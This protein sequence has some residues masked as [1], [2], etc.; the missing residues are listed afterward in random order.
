VE[1]TTRPAVSRDHDDRAS[2]RAADKR[3]DHRLFLRYRDHGDTA[4]REQL[5]ERFLPLA[6][7]LAG[8]YKRRSEPIDDLMQ[9][10]SMGLVKAVDRYDPSRGIAF[11]TFAVPTILGELKRYFRDS[12]WAVRVPRGMQERVLALDQA[13]EELRHRFGHSPSISELASRLDLTSEGVL[14][15]IEA[16]SA[17]ESTSLDSPDDSGESMYAS[18]LGRQESGFE[19]VE[20]RS[21]IV[22][23]ISR[24]SNRQRLVL[25]LRFVEDL[26]QSEIA[27][28]IGV[29]QM[30]VSRLLRRSLEELRAQTGLNDA[31]APDP[32]PRPLRVLRSLPAQ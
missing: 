1:L 2:A 19:L 11:S 6:R 9:V 28:R 21:A 27:D 23:G 32:S 8:R 18:A 14:L 24:L 12:S 20:D 31:T 15:A 22:P 16:A 4:A 30:H 25:H 3:K 10:A 13:A 26:T 17:F 29:S 7:R 5:I